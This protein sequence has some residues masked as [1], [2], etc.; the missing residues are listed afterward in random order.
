MLFVLLLPKILI[1]I[2]SVWITCKYRHHTWFSNSNISRNK[3]RKIHLLIDF[4][5]FNPSRNKNN[6]PVPSSEPMLHT[7][8]ETVVLSS[9]EGL[10]ECHQVPVEEPSGS[11]LVHKKLGS[12][13]YHL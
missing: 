6:Y 9:L 1:N 11:T 5:N 2:L 10:L 3:S 8:L 12:H 7:V 13:T 4:R